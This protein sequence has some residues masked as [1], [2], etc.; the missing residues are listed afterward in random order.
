MLAGLCSFSIDGYFEGDPSAVQ[1]SIRDVLTVKPNFSLYAPADVTPSEAQQIM[2]AIEN[3][4]VGWEQAKAAASDS[5]AWAVGTRGGE[6]I[7]Q[8]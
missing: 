1:K 5:E 8:L 3:M 2:G 4:R 7:H 6:D